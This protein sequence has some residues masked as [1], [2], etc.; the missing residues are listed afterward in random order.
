MSGRGPVRV[1]KTATFQKYAIREGIANASLLGAIERAGAGSV[2]A[3]LGGGLI[4]QRIGRRGAGKS[5]GYRTIILFRAGV[6]AVFVFGFAKSQRANLD[7][8]ETVVFKKAAKLVLALSDDA[9][10]AEVVSGRI[11]EISDGKNLQE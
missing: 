10:D 5:G 2:D 8:Q 11:I 1:F 6:R 7:R 4:K 3:D 9:L